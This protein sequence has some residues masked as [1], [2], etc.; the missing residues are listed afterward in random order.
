MAESGKRKWNFYSAAGKKFWQ[1]QFVRQLPGC[2]RVLSWRG[3]LS[4]AAGNLHG[5][6][7][8][9]CLQRVQ[10]CLKSIDTPPR[11]GDRRHWIEAENNNPKP[12][13]PCH[14]FFN[15]LSASLSALSLSS[16]SLCSREIYI[17]ICVFGWSRFERYTRTREGNYLDAVIVFTRFI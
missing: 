8:R 4:L 6:S 7:Q 15:S 11:T 12:I 9:G 10:M 16:A 13:P 14:F 5:L 17:Y 3:C 1:G 2:E